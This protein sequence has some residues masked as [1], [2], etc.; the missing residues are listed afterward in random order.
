MLQA[1]DVVLGLRPVKWGLLLLCGFLLIASIT[2]Q[3]RS[4]WQ[5]A[6]LA[7]IQAEQVTL[8]EQI[9]T[10]NREIERWKLEGQRQER[11]AMEAEEAA[12]EIRGD[13]EA[14][15]KALK[16]KFIREDCCGAIEDFKTI[17]VGGTP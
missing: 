2:L 15:I 14:R 17:M 7:T 9:K 3:I 13:Y 11:L 10:Q 1:I 8:F 6:E 4:K 16:R 5:G 12:L